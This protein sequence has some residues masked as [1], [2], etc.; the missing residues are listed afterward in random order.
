MKRLTQLLLGLFLVS[1][2][3]AQDNLTLYNMETL[4]QRFQVN[5]ALDP[6]C[7]W[8]IGTPAISSFNFGL[9]TNGLSLGRLNDALIPNAEDSFTLEVDRLDNI[10]SQTTYINTNITQD[11]IAF[12][13]RL[14]NSMVY[15]NITEKVKS[16]LALPRD[17]FSLVFEGNGGE[18]LGRTFDLNWGYD[19][20]HTREFA[21]GFQKSFFDQ[22]IKVGGRLKYIYG[23]NSIHTARN[24]IRLTT[25]PDDFTMTMEADIKLDMASSYLSY[26]DGPFQ[27]SSKLFGGARNRG[28]GVDLGASIDITEMFTVHGSIVDLGYINWT[29]N[30]R[31]IQSKNPGASFAYRGIDIGRIFADSIAFDEGLDRLADSLTE[32]FDLDTVSGE[33]F[34]TSLIGEF[35]LGGNLNITDKHN[36]GALLYGSFYNRQFYP[37]LT[38]SWNSRVGRVLGVSA[39]YTMM[40]GNFANAGLGISINGGPEQFYIVS[41]NLIGG[42]TGNIKNLNVRFGWNH[43]FGRKQWEEEN[44]YT[45]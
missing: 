45:K 11:W 42:L 43:T 35:Y 33:S 27:D 14:K 3:L 7:K 18:N 19:L 12:G 41:D 26:S 24:D 2:A 9:T 44:D 30:V 29:E 39:S 8:F 31:S 4:P 40:R 16:R 28:L 32:T 36:A 10:F 6:D 38:L 25:D 23:L 5:P 1:G 22:T 37:A 34:T 17:F 15:F 20:L 21:V 13:F